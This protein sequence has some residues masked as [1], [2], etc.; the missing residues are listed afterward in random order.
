M[1]I[2]WS[3]FKKDKWHC[4]VFVSYLS[5]SQTS[6]EYDGFYQILRYSLMMLRCFS[7]PLKSI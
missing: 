5:P 2:M 4:Y 3:Q 6:L 1:L 7:H